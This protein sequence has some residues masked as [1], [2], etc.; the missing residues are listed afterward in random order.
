MRKLSKTAKDFIQTNT[1]K[2]SGVIN[3]E[4][5]HNEDGTIRVS[6]INIGGP[7]FDADRIYTLTQNKEK[8][9]TSKSPGDILDRYTDLMMIKYETELNSLYKRDLQS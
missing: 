9:L 2:D 4:S 6:N 3:W 1:V 8:V 5:Y 7:G